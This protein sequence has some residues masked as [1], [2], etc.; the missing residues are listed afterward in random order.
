MEA[1]QCALAQ[2]RFA[3]QWRI[4]A[5]APVSACFDQ[6]VR[7]S[8]PERVGDKILRR[9]N[10]IHCPLRSECIH[11]CKGFPGKCSTSDCT[12][13]PQ[14][15]GVCLKWGCGSGATLALNLCPSCLCFSCSWEYIQ[16]CA[17][18]PS[19]VS[20][21]SS[22]ETCAS[23]GLCTLAASPV[24]MG[25]M[26][27]TISEAYSEGFV[28]KRGKLGTAWHLVLAI[29]SSFRTSF[30]FWDIAHSR[31]EWPCIQDQ[32]AFQPS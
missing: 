30:V 8:K 16:S 10:T 4:A 14:P 22:C 20:P 1:S 32:L 18:R 12:E 17:T 29:I 11:D 31:P 13:Q 25:I 15:Q 2:G 7:V 23:L 21:L 26:K 27:T 24:W 19:W 28:R 6:L 5:L 3:A 9:R